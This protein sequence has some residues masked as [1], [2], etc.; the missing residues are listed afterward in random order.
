MLNWSPFLSEKKARCETSCCLVLRAESSSA[1]FLSS[2]R[3]WRSSIRSCPL[4]PRSREGVRARLECLSCLS[5]FRFL[6]P[7]SFCFA[8]ESPCCA[9]PEVVSGSFLELPS[10]SGNELNE[11]GKDEKEG[12]TDM[13]GTR[14][15]QLD[16]HCRAGKLTLRN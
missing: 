13:R 12:G 16:A 8:L 14:K 10:R 9:E 15:S 7:P 6:R 1:F 2:S 4:L 11:G 3:V 5:R